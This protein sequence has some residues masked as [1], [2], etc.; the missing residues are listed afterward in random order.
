V[1]AIVKAS[2]YIPMSGTL[3]KFGEEVDVD[4][5]TMRTYKGY[6]EPIA[7]QQTAPVN[8]MV[9]AEKETVKTA[10]AAKRGRKKNVV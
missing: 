2:L 6:F 4:E 5:D 10:A 3:F 7:K 9:T 8:K 1:R